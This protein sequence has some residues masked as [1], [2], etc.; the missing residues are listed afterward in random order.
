MIGTNKTKTT[1]TMNKEDFVSHEIAVKLKELGFD[2]E[3]YE[4]WDT[5][6]SDEGTPIKI[7]NTTQE[8]RTCVI[9][10][11]NSI[12]ESMGCELI[13]APTM[14]KAQKWLREIVGIYVGVNTAIQIRKW[15]FYLDDLNQ[16][17]NPHDGELLTR[18][19][20]DMQDEYD[21]EYFDT[22]ESALSAGIT[23]AL[24]ILTDQAS[25]GA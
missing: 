19:P 13:T 18:C 11:R 9:S 2:W 20:E 15:Q 8:P 16:H 7:R 3:C 6:I 10:E 23:A 14:A 4:F 21:K 1:K 5:S 17:I 22:Y 12:L 24:E 25:V